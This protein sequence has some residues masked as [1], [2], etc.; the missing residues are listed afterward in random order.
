MGVSALQQ[1]LRRFS[2]VLRFLFA[3]ASLFRKQHEE[4]MEK[5]PPWRVPMT[6]RIGNGC[7]PPYPDWN[8]FMCPWE[9]RGRDH[10]GQISKQVFN[11]VG[12]A[13]PDNL[14]FWQTRNTQGRSCSSPVEPIRAGAPSTTEQGVQGRDRWCQAQWG[15]RQGGTMVGQPGF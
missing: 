11:P 9:W 10:S 12:W 15:Q 1:G 14:C 13:T 8:H 6:D 4:E 3:A 5:M 2:S 7:L